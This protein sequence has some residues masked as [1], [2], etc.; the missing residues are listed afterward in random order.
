MV[1]QKRVSP[2]ILNFSGIEVWLCGYSLA[3]EDVCNIRKGT[4]EY[5][6]FFFF[7]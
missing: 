7:F 4:E 1:S 2:A 6:F 3:M 5:H